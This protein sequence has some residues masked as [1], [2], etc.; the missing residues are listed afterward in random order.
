MN[1]DLKPVQFTGYAPGTTFVHLGATADGRQVFV[2]VP[3]NTDAEGMLVIVAQQRAAHEARP[4]DD[5]D[6]VTTFY[7]KG[8]G[9]AR[10]IRLEDI[11][12]RPPSWVGRG[13]RK[14]EEPTGRA[15]RKPEPI[16]G[17][18][19]PRNAPCPCGSGKKAKACCRRVVNGVL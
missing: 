14:L 13:F 1:A 6:R 12:P 5:P 10:T 17:S 16:R 19:A 11:K 3:P 7:G 18:A 9:P 2:P 4:A 15:E 8:V